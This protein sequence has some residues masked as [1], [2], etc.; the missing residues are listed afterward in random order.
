M[1][2]NS[3][4]QVL[5]SRKHHGP[6]FA[7]FGF[8]RRQCWF[9]RIG[10]CG[11][12]GRSGGNLCR[13]LACRPHPGRPI[14]GAQSRLRRRAFRSRSAQRGLRTFT[15]FVGSREETQRGL[16]EGRTAQLL[17]SNER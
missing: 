2:T 14:L 6:F 1:L 10:V 13:G 12:R 8:E 11:A 5:Q 16:D 17:Q 15:F 7:F 9:P 4:C 3:F